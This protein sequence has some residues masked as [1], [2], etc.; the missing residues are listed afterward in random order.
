MQEAAAVR[1]E[2]V[3]DGG[4][5]VSRARELCTSVADDSFALQATLT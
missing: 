4:N 3:D 5:D 2:L 1:A